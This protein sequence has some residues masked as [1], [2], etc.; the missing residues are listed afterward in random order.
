MGESV[1]PFLDYI[2]MPRKGV[3]LAEVTTTRTK[4]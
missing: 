4:H 3:A 1:V 2:T